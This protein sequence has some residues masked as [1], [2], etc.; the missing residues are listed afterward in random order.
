MPF[1]LSDKNRWPASP[2]DKLCARSRGPRCSVRLATHLPDFVSSSVPHSLSRALCPEGSHWR[3]PTSVLPQ[4]LC[5][6]CALPDERR[7]PEPSACPAPPQHLGLSSVLASRAGP[8]CLPLVLQG[9]T[10][11]HGGVLPKLSSW[12]SRDL[13]ILPEAAA[14][15]PE[16]SLT[17]GGSNCGITRPP[18]GVQTPALKALI[19]E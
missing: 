13:R 3:A 4:G 5:A 7:A 10:P 1:C 6:C 16:F 8:P 17:L 19:G 11:S 14:T 18:T 9:I 15:C 2:R 12:Q